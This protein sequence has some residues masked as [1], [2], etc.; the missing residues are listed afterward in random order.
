[1]IFQLFRILSRG[2]EAQC[3]FIFYCYIT[4]LCEEWKIQDLNHPLI[5]P[6]VIEWE[7]HLMTRENY[8]KFELKLSKSYTLPSK[9]YGSLLVWWIHIKLSALTPELLYDFCIITYHQV[10]NRY[11]LTGWFEQHT[12]AHY[13]WWL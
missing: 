11:L 1:M 7:K 8:A 4:S 10:K 5:P 6:N 2:V 13:F 3:V 9:Q 12:M